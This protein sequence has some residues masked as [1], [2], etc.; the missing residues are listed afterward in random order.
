MKNKLIIAYHVSIIDYLQNA[1]V[2]Q[3]L[4]MKILKNFALNAVGLVNLVN[5]IKHNA[6]NV[7]VIELVYHN[8]IALM[9]LMNQI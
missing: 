1:I 3:I 6:L 4:I 7:E 5:L 9:V 8:A 2:H